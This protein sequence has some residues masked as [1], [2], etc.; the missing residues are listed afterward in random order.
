MDTFAAWAIISGAIQ[1]AV[2]AGRLGQLDGQW[3]MIISGA[4]SIIA[5]TTFIDYNRSPAS[6]LH[7]LAQY[8]IGGAIWVPAHG[9]LAP[10]SQAR[11]TDKTSLNGACVVGES[12]TAPGTDRPVPRQSRRLAHHDPCLAERSDLRRM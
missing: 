3:P 9:P 11:S 2:G 8:S 10:L 6:A 4:G 12:R 5:A 1:L 7:A